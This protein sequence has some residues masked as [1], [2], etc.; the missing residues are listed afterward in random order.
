MKKYTALLIAAVLLT[1]LT[2][3][4]CAATPKAS[5][6][7]TPSAATTPEAS[8]TAPATETTP[9]ASQKP[10][11]SAAGE[12]SPSAAPSAS[13]AESGSGTYAQMNVN[14]ISFG[15]DVDAYFDGYKNTDS[16]LDKLQPILF[17]ALF[18][19]F[20]SEKMFFVDDNPVD[21]E[22]EWTTVYHL[23]NDFEF[24]RA[25]VTQ[26]AGNITV[27]ADIMAGFFMDEFGVST[28][29]E[30]PDSILGLVTFDK[31]AGAYTLM[32]TGIGGLNFILSNIV[33]SK[34]SSA[35][36]PTQSA[37]ITFDVQ[38]NDGK[39]LKTICVELV[40]APDSTFKYSVMDAYT[41][42]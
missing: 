11:P 39:T 7:A 24:E 31:D 42:E 4:S 38:D 28:I 3:S 14:K 37:T 32:S 19:A 17:S 26:D 29:P 34:A 36:D 6:S 16:A 27:P 20:D 23:I 8:A 35:A 10:E 40:R 2:L 30:I 13:P 41:A 21:A 1:G 15:G 22:F 25:G 18:A 12:N 5:P 33:L 9:A